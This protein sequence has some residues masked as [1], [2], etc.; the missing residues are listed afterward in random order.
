MNIAGF[1]IRRE[2]LKRAWS[3]EGLCDGICAVSYLSKI[4]QGKVEASTEVLKL[5]LERLDLSWNLTDTT[6]VEALVEE[7][8]EALLAGRESL[9]EEKLAPLLKRKDWE[10]GACAIDLLLLQKFF[11]QEKCFL[12]TELEPYMSNRQLGLQ[13]L[14]KGQDK[15]A[16]TIYPCAY[17]YLICGR[18]RYYNGEYPAATEMLRIACQMAAD[19]GLVYIMMLGRVYMGNCYSDMGDI[20]HMIENYVVANRLAEALQDVETQRSIQYN[21]AST[22][23]GCGQIQEAFPYFAELEHPSAM[24]L[25]KLAICYEQTGRTKEARAAIEKAYD[26]LQEE[27][28]DTKETIK[29]MLDVVAYRL[30]HTDYL[31]TDGYGAILLDCFEELQRTLPKGYAGFH[32]QW[33]LEWYKANRQY[34]QACALLEKFPQK[35]L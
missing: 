16:I 29:K 15:M 31:E 12:E 9:C 14:L 7:C 19:A 30:A 4:E 3:Q 8:Y 17:F 20:D 32:L 2:R 26:L 33:V 24:D 27:E 18:H 5:L 10:C 13:Y 25:H 1:V 23:L 21:I 34:K 35:T 28:A 11:M 6:E 22:R